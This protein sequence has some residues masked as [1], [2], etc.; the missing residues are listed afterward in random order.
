MASLETENAEQQ[1]R[2]QAHIDGN[3][4]GGKVSSLRKSKGG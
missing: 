3:K 4:R 1:N 2:E